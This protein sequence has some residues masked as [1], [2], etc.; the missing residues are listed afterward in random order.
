LKKHFCRAL[1]LLGVLLIL[2]SMAVPVGAELS[3]PEIYTAYYQIDGEMIR[4]IAPGTTGEKLG[5]VCTGITAAPEGQ[6]AT[7]DQLTADEQSLTVIVTADL[8]D[9]S[10][11]AGVYTAPAAVYVDSE[12]D[13]GVAGEYEVTVRIEN[14]SAEG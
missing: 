2:I 13:V 7:G 3:Q 1:S 8:S 11:S 6:L 5:K 10:A 9:I 4:G 14:I 12:A